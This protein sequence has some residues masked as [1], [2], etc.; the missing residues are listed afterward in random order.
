MQSIDQKKLA[1]VC[2]LLEGGK[3]L[4]FRHHLALGADPYILSQDHDQIVGAAAA[5]F[6]RDLASRLE[7]QIVDLGLAEKPP[8][9]QVLDEQSQQLAVG[10]DLKLGPCVGLA[11]QCI[12]NSLSNV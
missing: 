11:P 2:A 7:Q 5:A 12:E 10:V 8:F 3:P 6:V 9:A 1:A 4:Y